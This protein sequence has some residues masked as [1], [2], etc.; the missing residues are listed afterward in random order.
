VG[1]VGGVNVERVGDAGG[2]DFDG[3]AVFG[4]EGAIFE[5]GGEKIDDG[6]S[7]T[8]FRVEGGRLDG[9]LEVGREMVEERSTMLALGSRE[10][11]DRRRLGEYAQLL[12][13]L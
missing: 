10:S 3:F 8:L 12:L 2:G 9:W 11:Q 5:G 4:G 1:F 7:E 6:E 13:W